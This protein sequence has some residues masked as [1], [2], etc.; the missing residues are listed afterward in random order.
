MMDLPLLVTTAGLVNNALSSLKSARDLAKIASDNDLKETIGEAYETLLDLR[1]R[2]LT[3]D[4][5]NRQ[6]K[7]QLATKAAYIGPVAPHGYFYAAED[8][9][10]QHPL[11]P[12]CFQH[13]PQQIGF[14]NARHQW[15]GGVR[16]ECKK[17]GKSLYEAP[18]SRA[19]VT[20]AKRFQAQ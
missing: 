1:E 10:H 6:L 2:V 19:T 20:H 7:A 17:C 9:E 16:R 18:M 15:N 5:E 13:E 12:T 4:E 3:L 11:C 14:M 8:G